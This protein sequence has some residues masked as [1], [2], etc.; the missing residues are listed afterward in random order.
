[1][2]TDTTGVDLYNLDLT[3]DPETQNDVFLLA[4]NSGEG[5]VFDGLYREDAISNLSGAPLTGAERTA[6]ITEILKHKPGLEATYRYALVAG[7]VSMIVVDYELEVPGPDG[8]TTLRRG[9]C[10]DVMRRG[11]DGKWRMT[12]DRPVDHAE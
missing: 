1:M 12:I 10:T 11:A 9:T 4:F 6:A 3:D 2:T 7:D 5:A 8:T